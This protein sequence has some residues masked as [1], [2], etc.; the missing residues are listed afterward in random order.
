MGQP[1]QLCGPARGHPAQSAHRPKSHRVAAVHVLRL[2]NLI[3]A[4]L[5]REG[6][7]PFALC[8]S[9]GTASPAWLLCLPCAAVAGK[10]P[11]RMWVQPDRAPLFLKLPAQS[12][13]CQAGPRRGWRPQAVAPPR[14]SRCHLPS[15]SSS[16]PMRT[17]RLRPSPTPPS[18]P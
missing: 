3:L 1:T 18:P 13:A 5:R 7:T 17:A 8:S 6:K 10:P 14:A 4:W 9:Q 2:Y 11:R 16:M 15:N 12:F